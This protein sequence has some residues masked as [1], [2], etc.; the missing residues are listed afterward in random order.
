ML[1]GP[2][3]AAAAAPE[4]ELHFPALEDLKESIAAPQPQHGTSTEHR[5]RPRGSL[6]LMERR[7]QE[8]VVEEQAAALGPALGLAPHHQLA[9]TGCLQ[10]LVRKERGQGQGGLPAMREQPGM[11][12]G[13]SIANPSW[14]RGSAWA[15]QP[16]K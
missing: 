6:T 15:G 8:G 5:E 3:D 13:S 14:G 4:P 2:E 16:E 10:T 1:R 7:V 9:V 12:T 11:G